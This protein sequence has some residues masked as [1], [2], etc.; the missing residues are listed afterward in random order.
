MIELLPVNWLVTYMIW[1]KNR[2]VLSRHSM[3]VCKRIDSMLPWV[4]SVIDHRGGQNLLK[5]SGT[6]SPAAR[7]LLHFNVFC[8]LLLNR[9]TATRN[10]FVK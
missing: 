6:H 3:P 8:D 1:D 10:L 5:A 2:L 4:C 7:G 9:R